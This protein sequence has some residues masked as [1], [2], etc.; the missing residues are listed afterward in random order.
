M[1]EINN[2]KS[3]PNWQSIETAPKDNERCL[4]LAR[5]NAEGQLMELDFDGIWEYWEESWEM[6]HIN[7]YCWQ[8]ANGIEEPTHW[9]YQDEPLPT[10]FTEPSSDMVEA[11]LKAACMY[12][13]PESRKD[14]QKAIAAALA[15]I[16]T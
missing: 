10:K 8:S 13:T 4:Y 12:S 9:A 15:L 1:D 7:G 14:M 5:F 16:G 3:I 11:A 2:M 6:S